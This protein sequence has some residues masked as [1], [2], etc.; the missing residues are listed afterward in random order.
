[1][2]R[3]LIEHLVCRNKTRQTCSEIGHIMVLNINGEEAQ[4]FT[5][6]KKAVHGW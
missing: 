1:M 4:Q 2:C 3:G 6:L 5:H